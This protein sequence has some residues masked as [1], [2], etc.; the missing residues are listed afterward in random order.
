[1]STAIVAAENTYTVTNVLQH[2]LETDTHKKANK[3][4]ESRPE[5]HIHAPY[6]HT[7]MHTRFSTIFLHLI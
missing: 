3:Q 7:Q 4:K 6:T 2:E 1:M 5:T